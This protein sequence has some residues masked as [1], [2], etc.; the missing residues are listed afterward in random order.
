M[1][2]SIGVRTGVGV[3]ERLRQGRRVLGRHLPAG[4]AGFGGVLGVTNAIALVLGVAAS[5][6]LARSL[7]QAE[8]GRVVFGLNLFLATTLIGGFGLTTA[9]AADV[10]HNRGGS[11]EWLTVRRLWGL[12]L[13][14]LPTI[15]AVVGV[16]VAWTGWDGLW[17]VAVAASLSVVLDFF[18]G[19]FQGVQ[20][21]RALVVIL[22]AQPGLYLLTL[23]TWPAVTAEQ[24]F[25][26]L[27]ASFV[28]PVIAVFGTLRLRRADWTR[29]W[30]DRVAWRQFRPTSVATGAYAITFLQVG[31]LTV[32]P[33]ALGFVERFQEAAVLAV[34]LALVR[35]VPG[36]WNTV[37]AAVLFPRLAAHRTDTAGRAGLVGGAARALAVVTVPATLALLAFPEVGLTVLFGATY[38]SAADVVALASVLVVALA[39]EALLT[40]T[41]LGVGPPASAVTGTSLRLALLTGGVAAIL[42]AV[43]TSDDAVRL[44]VWA[45]VVAAVV[46]VVVQAIFIRDECNGRLLAGLLVAGTIAAM[47]AAGLGWLGLRAVS[48][49]PWAVAV[50]GCASL[51]M[52]GAVATV[53]T[54]VRR[55]AWTRLGLGR[56]RS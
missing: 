29:P 34:V 47:P 3:A 46:G 24:V 54:G 21:L 52:V 35:L 19:I 6:V 28:G 9:V 41:A 16:V 55:P 40:W 50:A 32:G 18:V 4:A 5:L 48:G 7:P 27:A 11:A 23:L 43:P 31:F 51:A 14:T 2:H 33:L 39:G 45:H 37:L 42:L 17:L 38:A 13:A 36:M 22:V 30:L 49:L 20:H 25:G 56:A 26:V 15:A 44:V 12:R 1:R 10:A 53:V 8:F